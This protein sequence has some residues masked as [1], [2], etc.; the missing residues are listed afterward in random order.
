MNKKTGRK[1]TGF[2]LFFL[3][4]R[5]PVYL[6]FEIFPDIECEERYCRDA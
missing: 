1:K 4:E 3:A 5:S 2:R 6:H